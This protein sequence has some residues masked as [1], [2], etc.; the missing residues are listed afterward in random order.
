MITFFTLFINNIVQIIFL[1]KS[2]PI[3]RIATIHFIGCLIEILETYWII[4]TWHYVDVYSKNGR[5]I[6]LIPIH[7]MLAES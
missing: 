5:L 1:A 3:R 2:T 7:T 6:S 4:S